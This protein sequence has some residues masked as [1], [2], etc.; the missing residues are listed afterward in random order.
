M[1]DKLSGMFSN[2]TVGSVVAIILILAA[3]IGIALFI[4][5]RRSKSNKIPSTSRAIRINTPVNEPVTEAQAD[6]PEEDQEPETEPAYILT[7]DGSI[8]FDFIPVPLGDVFVADTSMT[9]SG[10]CYLVKETAPS[11]YEAYDPRT[12]P[13]VSEET[14]INAWFATHWD[15]V[16]EVFSVIPPW[17]KS[18]SLWIAALT[19]VAA[20]IVALALVG[21]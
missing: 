12:A 13:L 18:T 14:P 17:W 20:F 8:D 21:G 15:I 4:A 9:K 19:G 11:I 6:E 2:V 10:P 5:W 3:I 16:R 1:F 7:L